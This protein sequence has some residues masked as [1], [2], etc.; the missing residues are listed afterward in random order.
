MAKP[1]IVFNDRIE[2]ENPNL[3]AAV[4]AWTLNNVTRTAGQSDPVGGTAAYLLNATVGGG[5]AAIA[6]AAYSSDGT[7][8]VALAV[9]AGSSSVTNVIIRDD[10][11]AVE[12]HNI[13]IAWNAG[14]PT[15]TSAGGS[16]TIYDPIV[17][18]GG[19]YVVAFTA[20]G[21]LAANTNRVWVQPAG[22]S[23]G[24]VYVYAPESLNVATRFWVALESDWPDPASRFANWT[25]RK[26]PV[27]DSAHVM[28][29]EQRYM[30][31]TSWRYGAT[32][33]IRGIQMGAAAGSA[34]DIADR[35]IAHL[36]N[37]GTCS[38]YAEDA[39]G[40]SYVTCGVMPG[41]EPELVPAD[42]RK[43]EYSLA[44]ALINLASSPVQMICH[45][46]S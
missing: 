25:P 16:G 8:I 17:L 44:L 24:T 21:V 12:R 38:V 27:G 18:S 1:R 19:W 32:F 40:S 9:K 20:T 26:R 37:D 2:A 14:V 39:L 22:G 28:A 4:S 5:G 41:T 31:R 10:T 42:R 45:Y 6:A 11:A 46:S 13:Q 29:N 15:V 33:E 35:L 34:L 3:L 43:I 7:K 23:T 30:F 36:L